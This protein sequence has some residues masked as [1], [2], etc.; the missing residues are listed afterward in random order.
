MSP[1]TLADFCS[2][3][4]DFFKVQR[5]VSFTVRGWAWM[6]FQRKECR[7]FWGI[8]FRK[9]DRSYIINNTDGNPRAEPGKPV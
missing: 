9:T 3:S 1:L 6:L 7:K 4:E 5:I 2:L 8:C